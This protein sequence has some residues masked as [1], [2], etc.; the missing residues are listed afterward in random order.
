VLFVNFSL[1]LECEK[2]ASEKIEIQRHYVMV[3]LVGERHVR[4]GPPSHTPPHT[5]LM[6]HS[7]NLNITGGDLFLSSDYLNSYSRR[8]NVNAFL[9]Y[10]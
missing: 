5:Y 6:E 4:G 7:F 1:K 3:S 9:L 10:H 2:L 8:I